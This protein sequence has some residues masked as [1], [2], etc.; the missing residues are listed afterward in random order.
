M[1]DQQLV[2]GAISTAASNLRDTLA[3]AENLFKD[4]PAGFLDHIGVLLGGIDAYT[5]LFK[6]TGFKSK[7]ELEDGVRKLDN[8]VRKAAEDLLDAE[9]EW[10]SFLSRVENASVVQSGTLPTTSLLEVGDFLPLDLLLFQVGEDSPTSLKSVLSSGTEPY[11]HL[12]LNRF[13]G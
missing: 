8:D 2:S 13:F 6:S 10:E 3:A 5:A 7:Q 9:Q 1:A 12:V 4:N 11:T